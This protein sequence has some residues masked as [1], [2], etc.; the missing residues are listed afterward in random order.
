MVQRDKAITNLPK[1]YLSTVHISSKMYVRQCPSLFLSNVLEERGLRMARGKSVVIIGAKS[2]G[3]KAFI[4][5][6]P[7]VVVIVVN[8]KQFTKSLRTGTRA[9]EVPP[10]PDNC[11]Y[12]YNGDGV[13]IGFWCIG[14]SS[15]TS[16]AEVNRLVQKY[17][18]L[19]REGYCDCE[20]VNGTNLCT[21]N[22]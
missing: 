9:G 17:L 19:A 15:G 4:V 8:L 6:N 2:L 22:F 21:C 5:K 12:V 13:P 10:P 7:N 20:T 1:S 3:R 18:R 11:I 14:Q 16:R